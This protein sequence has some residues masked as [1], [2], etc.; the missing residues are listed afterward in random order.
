MTILN[1]LCQKPSWTSQDCKTAMENS[2]PDVK[3]RIDTCAKL[4]P[5]DGT[6]IPPDC[7]TSDGIYNLDC[8]LPAFVGTNLAQSRICYMN[9]IPS[10]TNP[11]SVQCPPE[12]VSENFSIASL[13]PKKKKI[14]LIITLSVVG[15]IVLLLLGL[16]WYKS[17]KK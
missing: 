4:G 15:F 14:A 16:W 11:N 3:K 13:S 2:S 12:S 8:D 6:P 17:S 9:N 10:T 1:D 7:C 5:P